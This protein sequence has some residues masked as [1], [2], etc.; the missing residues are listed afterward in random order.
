MGLLSDVFKG[1]RYCLTRSCETGAFLCTGLGYIY[2]F[3]FFDVNVWTGKD[4]QPYGANLGALPPTV[5][6][7][8][9]VTSRGQTD[10]EDREFINFPCYRSHCNFIYTILYRAKISAITYFCRYQNLLN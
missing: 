3:I 6:S 7:C 1:T 10:A 5:R 8:N 4:I 9:R 2:I